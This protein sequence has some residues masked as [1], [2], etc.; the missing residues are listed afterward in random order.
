MQREK[1]E[2]LLEKNL[3]QRYHVG[4]ILSTDML[5][6]FTW[7]FHRP[8]NKANISLL[9]LLIGLTS[10]RNPGMVDDGMHVI[11]QLSHQSFHV[12]FSC[13]KFFFLL[14]CF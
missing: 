8:L 3:G 4:D 7:H 9:V 11:S 5:A 14:V 12:I 10:G 13:H 2:F 6:V 1:A